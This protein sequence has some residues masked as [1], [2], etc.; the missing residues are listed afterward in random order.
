MS[1]DPLNNPVYARF[2]VTPLI[3]DNDGNELKGACEG[4]LCIK[5]SWPGMM[6][7]VYRD[8]KRFRDTYFSSFK[9]KFTETLD[10]PFKCN[11]KNKSKRLGIYYDV[12]H[13][14]QFCVYTQENH[15]TYI[16]QLLQYKLSIL[17]MGCTNMHFLD[18]SLLKAC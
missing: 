1:T 16:W 9:G 11:N 15:L 18:G 17:N 4:N 14:N 7:T 3:V 2:G 13:I 6:R 8:H 5:T 12:L 10:S